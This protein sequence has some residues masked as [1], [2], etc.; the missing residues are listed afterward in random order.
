MLQYAKQS[1]LTDKDLAGT[2]PTYPTLTF[3]ER[4]TLDLGNK[5]IEVLYLGPAHTTGS[6]VVYMPQ[7][8]V[9]FAGDL[10]F[11]A[12]HPFLGEAN[13]EGWTKVLDHLMAMD[14]DKIIPGHGPLSSKKDLAD[15]KTYLLVFDRKAKELTAQSKDLKVIVP[16]MKKALPH[17][18]QL[19]SLISRNIQMKYLSP[20]KQAQPQAK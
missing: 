2:K 10:L 19:D 18:A 16:E 12:Y 8:K 4:L 11:T 15:L 5:K 13:I 1:G 20:G 6:V 7:E 9:L 14:V 3:K 17:R